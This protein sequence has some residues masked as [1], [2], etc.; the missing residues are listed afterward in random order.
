MLASLPSSFRLQRFRKCLKACRVSQ[1]KPNMAISIARLR[2]C[3]FLLMCNFICSC[4]F[5][6]VK[7]VQRQMGP[8]LAT[9]FPLA[10]AKLMLVPIVW[11]EQR[12][13][14]QGSNARMPA[15]DF[16]DFILLGVLG[17]VVAQLFV[18]WGVR[19]SPASN[20]ALIMRALAK[21][22]DHGSLSSF[23][24]RLERIIRELGLEAVVAR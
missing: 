7:I 19:Y 12:M 14:A 10:M 21:R 8:I 16:V 18:T 2:N 17:Q 4:Q 22:I 15:R 1:R 11:H 6:L 13:A 3:T 9:A 20:G 5:V 23:E 24:Q